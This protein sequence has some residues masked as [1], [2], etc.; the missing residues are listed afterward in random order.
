MVALSENSG[1]LCRTGISGGNSQLRSNFEKR[2]RG[3]NAQFESGSIDKE[4]SSQ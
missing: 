2:L 3:S 1:L 4:D